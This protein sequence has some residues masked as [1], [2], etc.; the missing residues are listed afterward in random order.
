MAKTEIIADSDIKISGTV[1]LGYKGFGGTSIFFPLYQKS[2][3]DHMYIM[4][5]VLKY[6]ERVR[7]SRVR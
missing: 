7:F 5:K 3:G 2:V 1:K 6:R 4:Y